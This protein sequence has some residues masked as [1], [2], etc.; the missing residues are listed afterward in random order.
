L[1]T[2]KERAGTSPAPTKNLGPVGTIRK[3]P[4]QLAIPP[5]GEP[6]WFISS[7][8]TVRAGIGFPARKRC[9]GRQYS[10]K[11]RKFQFLNQLELIKYIVRVGVEPR[12]NSLRDKFISTRTLRAVIPA[13]A[14]IQ[15]FIISLISKQMDSCLHRNDK[16]EISRYKN[17]HLWS[18][19][20]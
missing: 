6:L 14:G 8:G 1:W 17:K 15:V 10:A 19:N 13:K 18:V 11:G 9:S 3:L 7:Q 12:T 4:L 20:P 16:Q 2:P 5:R